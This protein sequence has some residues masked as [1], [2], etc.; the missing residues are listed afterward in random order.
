MIVGTSCPTMTC[1]DVRIRDGAGKV[2]LKK[3]IYNFI[4]HD[5]ESV[6][7]LLYTAFRTQN[8]L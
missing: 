5:N 6:L 8:L 2:T 7:F 3:Y 4:N 1:G